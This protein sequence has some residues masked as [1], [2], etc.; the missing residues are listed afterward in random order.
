MKLVKEGNKYFIETTTPRKTSMCHDRSWVSYIDEAGRKFVDRKY[1]EYATTG[2]NGIVRY[3]VQPG[4]E[5]LY[6]NFHWQG[7]SNYSYSKDGGERGA[8]VIENGEMQDIDP[9][10]IYKRLEEIKKKQD[11]IKNDER[12]A[13]YEE[14]LV[15]AQEEG[16]PKLRGSEKQRKW[17]EV[18]RRKR[19]SAE[20]VKVERRLKKIEKSAEPVAEGLQKKLEE[21]GY[22]RVITDA[23]WW[24]RWGN[25]YC[26]ALDEIAEQAAKDEQR[27]KELSHPLREKF[28]KRIQGVTDEKIRVKT[29]YGEDL[30]DALKEIGAKWNHAMRVWELPI[31]M[32]EKLTNL[33]EEEKEMV[34]K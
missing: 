23:E 3:E 4:I 15:W 16:L 17:A 6:G 2:T 19:I 31:K 26:L 28:P 34:T 10:P 13:E 25:M 12:Q 20:I 30:V 8:F 18:I 24:I 22:Y 33:L 9:D 32:E 11:Q 14:A 5:Y 29:E 21:L 27:R 7:Q 1:S